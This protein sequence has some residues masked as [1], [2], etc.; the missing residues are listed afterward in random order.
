[1]PNNNTPAPL[2]YLSLFSGV[3][4][5]DLGFDRAGMICAGQVEI[6]DYCRRVL[7]KHW[8]DVKRMA[9]VREVKGDEFGA[10]D[11]I[12]GGFPCQDISNAA[13]AQGTPAGLAGT[14]SGLWAEFYR[15]IG[16]IRPR[17]A[18]VENVGAITVRGLPQVIG[19]LAEIGYDAEWQIVP[20]A[21]VGAPHLRERLFIVAHPHSA[22][23][24]GDECPILAG[25][26]DWRQHADATRSAWWGSE[27]AVGR[28]ADGVPRRVDRLRALGN[29]VVPQVAEWIG[30]RIMEANY[31]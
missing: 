6:D 29:A 15:L 3:G 16:I 24:E 21:Y 10:I 17:F 31:R 7:A 4:G 1:M 11:L 8:P 28:V 9:D 25:A 23:L 12:C 5:F 30:R 13:T 19:D 26:S 14:R 27:P 2:R 22:G 20:A 18:V